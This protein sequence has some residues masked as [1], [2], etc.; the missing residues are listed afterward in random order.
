MSFVGLNDDQINVYLSKILK[1]KDLDPDYLC[2]SE[3]GEVVAMK[4]GYMRVMCRSP[5]ATSD[6]VSIPSSME[7]KHWDILNTKRQEGKTI[8]F[9]VSRD[10]VKAKIQS[11]QRRNQGIPSEE[12]LHKASSKTRMYVDNKEKEFILVP[13]PTH[14]AI[15]KIKGLKF[16]L[17]DINNFQEMDKSE[18]AWAVRFFNS[19]ETRVYPK[20]YSTWGLLKDD[21]TFAMTEENYYPMG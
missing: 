16:T 9:F 12:D 1:F 13:R 8:F 11:R 10:Y 14:T 20:I 19:V 21:T 15:L 7:Q 4:A 3:D 5:S 2:E 6:D 18:N 17:H